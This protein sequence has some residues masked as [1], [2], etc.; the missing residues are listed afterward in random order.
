MRLFD[1]AEPAEGLSDLLERERQ[2]ILKGD[3]AI[4]ASLASEKERYY[5]R[6]ARDRPSANRLS[7]LQIKAN[8]NQVLLTAAADGIRSVVRDLGGSQRPISLE[9]YDRAGS[10]CAISG[11]SHSLERRY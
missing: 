2:A 3:Y 11:N 10:R 6:I 1:R 7:A 9:T 4:L 8:R 5:A